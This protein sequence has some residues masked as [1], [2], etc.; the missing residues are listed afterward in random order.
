MVENAMNMLEKSPCIRV[1]IA[2]RYAA[3]TTA[4]SITRDSDDHRL[5]L[6][7]RL[8]LYI[9]YVQAS[10]EEVFEHARDRPVN[11]MSDRCTKVLL[12]VHVRT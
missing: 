6:S 3:I 1:Y 5:M 7:L 12:R 2:I 11:R 9:T 8:L 4:T 10:R